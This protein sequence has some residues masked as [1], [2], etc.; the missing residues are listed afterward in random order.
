[1]KA[2]LTQQYSGALSFSDFVRET[3]ADWHRLAVTLLAQWRCPT[4]V[5]TDDIEQ[6]L[7]CAAWLAIPK[8]RADGTDIKHFVVFEAM[9]AAK[10]WLHKQRGVSVHGNPGRLAS[11]HD[12]L[13]DTGEIDNTVEAEQEQVVWAL[14]RLRL[15][16]RLMQPK[17]RHTL[18]AIAAAG[19]I[20]GARSLLSHTGRTVSVRSG[21]RVLEQA[22]QRL[23][24]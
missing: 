6:E 11:C 22:V 20:D 10:R 7:L 14:E 24:Q 8:W 2:Q 3:R 23:E 17:S 1:M 12:L 13:T 16:S 4:S 18:F 5:D 19:S 21:R 15:A 9:S